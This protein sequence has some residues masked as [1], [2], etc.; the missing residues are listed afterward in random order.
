M[1]QTK[2]FLMIAGVIAFLSSCLA[3]YNGKAETEAGLPGTETPMVTS[4]L[5]KPQGDGATGLVRF[6]S[7]DSY[8]RNPMGYTLWT[9]SSDGGAFQERTVVVRKTLGNSIAGYGVIICS[10]PRDVDG[11]TETVF[12][13]VM[14]NNNKQYAIGKVIGASY[15]PLVNWTNSTSLR[16][17]IGV[18]NTLK[19]IKSRANAYDL[20]CNNIFERTFVDEEMPLC[21]GSGRNGYIVVIAPDDMDQG[22]VEVWF[23]EL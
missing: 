3:P 21:E 12:L 5:F 15:T 9:Y 18:E 14:I 4:D 23:N 22:A 2:A 20:Y 16:S 6:Y 8:Y 7:N 13:T 1:K 19:I 11:Q 10:A 17:G